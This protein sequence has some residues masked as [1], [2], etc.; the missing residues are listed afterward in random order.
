MKKLLNNFFTIHPAGI[1]VLG[2]IVAVILALA[3][4]KN[5]MVLFALFMLPLL[6]SQ[7]VLPPEDE[8]EE[9]GEYDGGRLGF[10]AN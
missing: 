10:T 4:T 7:Q 6:Q 1:S 2:V 8:I 9:D 5:V 3:L